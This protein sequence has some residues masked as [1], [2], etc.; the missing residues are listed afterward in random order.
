[1]DLPQG[2]LQRVVLD[3]WGRKLSKEQINDIVIGI[4]EACDEAYPNIP[5][6]LLQ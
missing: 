4:K 1:M 3:I 6:D 2:S 5:V